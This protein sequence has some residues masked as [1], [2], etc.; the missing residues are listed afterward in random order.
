M[1]EKKLVRSEDDKVITGVCGGLAK[2]LGID[3]SLLRI[4]FVL[5]FIF[6]IGFPILIYAIMAIVMPKDDY[7][8][9]KK[10]NTYFTE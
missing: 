9:P 2:Y 4:I 8:F 10:D 1:E 7:Y 5:A 3:S 6:G